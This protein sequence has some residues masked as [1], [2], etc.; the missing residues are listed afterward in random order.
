MAT[1]A[2]LFEALDAL[3]A[4]RPFLVDDVSRRTG[5]TLVP[6]RDQ[7]DGAF[8]VHRGSDPAGA[9]FVEAELRV[10]GPAAT[11]PDGILILW[12]S[13]AVE[14]TAR[15]VTSRLGPEQDLI[16]P[17]PRQPADAPVYAVYRN[18]WGHLR[19]GFERGVR[20]RLVR[21]VL[22]ATGYP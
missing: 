7:T 16:V 10:P 6:G 13:P 12:V 18:A 5:L 14:V 22:D 1:E 9:L 15:A 19:L 4:S 11:A 8:A 20:G 17:T 2:E 3:E 21:I